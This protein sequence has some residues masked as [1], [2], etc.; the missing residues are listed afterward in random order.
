M[1]SLESP[2]TSHAEQ[3]TL[4]TRETLRQSLIL[5]PYNGIIQALQDLLVESEG[6]FDSLIGENQSHQDLAIYYRKTVQSSIEGLIKE[7]KE[8]CATSLADFDKQPK[9]V[10]ID[11]LQ[12]WYT[13]TA[14]KLASVHELY[15][16]KGRV[17]ITGNL[18]GLE[19]IMAS[20]SSEG[21]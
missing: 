21:M 13:G 3:E 17:L 16:Q 14:E 18:D 7:V 1:G 4:P 20:T 5:D 15:L 8:K 19:R 2:F 10:T 11:Q 6:R 12:N 9:T